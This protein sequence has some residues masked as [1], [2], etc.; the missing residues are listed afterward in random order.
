MPP[1]A[2]PLAKG[3]RAKVV[4]VAPDGTR[5]ALLAMARVAGAQTSR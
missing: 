3:H 5:G 2:A 1:R 4:P